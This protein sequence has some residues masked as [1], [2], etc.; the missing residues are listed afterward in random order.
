MSLILF[1]NMAK[2]VVQNDNQLHAWY[3][4]KIVNPNQF[5]RSGLKLILA[6]LSNK[7]SDFYLKCGILEWV[8]PSTE[9]QCQ[10]FKN[11]IWGRILAIKEG[12]ELANP[13][14]TTTMD[15][16]YPE[17]FDSISHI[18]LMK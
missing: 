4:L 16:K 8:C 9:K 3:F 5:H 14:P 7:Y 10:H 2:N 17:L 11:Q 1:L 6:V 18:I 15:N 13:L 12:H